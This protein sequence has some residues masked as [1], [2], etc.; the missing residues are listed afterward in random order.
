MVAPIRNPDCST[1]DTLLTCDTFI[2]CFLSDRIL[3]FIPSSVVG[4]GPGVEV[5]ITSGVRARV[6]G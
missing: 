1:I 2:S 5:I 6:R 3:V 4:M